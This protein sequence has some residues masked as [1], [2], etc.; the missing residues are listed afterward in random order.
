MRVFVVRVWAPRRGWKSGCFEKICASLA[1]LLLASV[2]NPW[3]LYGERVPA[4]SVSPRSIDFGKLPLNTIGH[5]TVTIRNIGNYVLSVREVQIRGSHTFRLMGWNGEMALEPL[6][7][8]RLDFDFRPSAAK[9]HY[10]T[11]IIAC[12]GVS[13]SVSLEG[14]G[15]TVSSD[16]IS[17]SPTTA[18]L[19]AGKSQQFHAFALRT[20]R[21]RRE[22][23]SSKMHW[24][25]D[26][27]AGGN[28][29]VGTISSEGLYAAPRDVGTSSS[30]VITAADETNHASA[31]V[32]ILPARMPVSV[33]ISPTS[34]RLQVGQS[35][36]FTAAVS[37][38]SN[39]AVNWLV[40]GV[41]G[42]NASV[43]KISASGLYTAPSSLAAGSIRVTAQSAARPNTFADANVKIF[44]SPTTVKV[45]ISPASASVQGKRSQQFTATVS[46][47]SNMAVN[48]LVAGIPG[49]NLSVGFI[50]ATGLYTAPASAPTNT[51]T[52]TAESAFASA[53]ANAI[54]TIL[55]VP[56]P[57]FVTISPEVATLEVN[58]SQ[59]F[60]A[61]VTGTTN[62]GV[63]W[64]VDGVL[65]GNSSVGTI[66]PSGLYTAPSTEVSV[67]VTAQSAFDSLRSASAAVTV[68]PGLHSVAVAWNADISPVAG[69][70]IYRGTAPGGPYTRLSFAQTGTTFVDTTVLSGQTYFYRTT[71]VDANGDESS[72]SNEVS[73]T[74]P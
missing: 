61:A 47:I 66:S 26:G 43:G 30:V 15:I 18:V 6:Q 39:T 11:L 16:G 3:S 69:Y 21:E 48:W 28:P 7:S 37:G 36:Q 67:T 33:S 60:N 42:G 70:N 20:R 71:A 31:K 29:L 52:V 34:T 50:S 9:T 2:L 53:S 24:L 5:R 12:S 35:Q 8:L 27:V 14:T 19:Q 54:V 74:V 55:P 44:P 13:H 49:G 73:A 63:N 65:G 25:A 4:L 22:G 62:N 59:Q 72:Y 32:T 51:V 38:I 17:I 58:K 57:V 41:P 10:A 1:L 45:S 23:L 40:E 68:K 64:L 46:G 56:A